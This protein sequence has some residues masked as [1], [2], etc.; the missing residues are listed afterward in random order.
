[1][2]PITS[3]LRQDHLEAAYVVTVQNAPDS[4][5]PNYLALRALTRWRLG[6]DADAMADASRAIQVAPND[7]LVRTVHGLTSLSVGALHDA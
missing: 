2:D 4:P 3:H 7:P 1:M 5:E 6:H